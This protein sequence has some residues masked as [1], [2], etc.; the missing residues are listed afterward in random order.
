MYIVKVEI[1]TESK[2]NNGTKIICHHPVDL[3]IATR[4]FTN[5][6]VDGYEYKNIFNEEVYKPS[7]NFDEINTL[8]Y[9]EGNV[10]ALKD[11]LKVNENST[12]SKKLLEK[13]R[14]ALNVKA[15]NNENFE[16]TLFNKTNKKVEDEDLSL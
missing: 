7:N 6:N 9:Q 1:V 16:N 10:V 15:L 13:F 12:A 5:I 3:A 2:Q 11:L 14:V 8:V 4:N